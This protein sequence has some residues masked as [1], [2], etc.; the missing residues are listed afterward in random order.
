MMTGPLTGAT[1]DV[2]RALLT[3]AGDRAVE[4]GWDQDRRDP[5]ITSQDNGSRR[6]RTAA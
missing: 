3:V 1:S 6:C 2:E 4:P 5:R